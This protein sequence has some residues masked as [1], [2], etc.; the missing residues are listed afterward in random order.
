VPPAD[1]RERNAM[2]NAH[3]I[4]MTVLAAAGATLLTSV[5]LAPSTAVAAESQ[6]LGA[7]VGKPLRAAQEAMNAKDWDTALTHIAEAKAIEP[8]TPYEAFMI[9]ELTWYTT[10]QKKDNAGAATALASAV[11]SGFVPEADLPQRYKVLTQLNYQL[12]DY[13][14]AIEY[15][16]KHLGL[17]PGSADVGTIV[18][19]SLYQQKDYAAARAMAEKTAALSTPPNEQLL[20]IQLRSSY[21]LKDQAGTV[22]ALES[23]V[24]NYPQPKYWEDLLNSQLY[25]TKSD[26][27]LRALYR[28]M[29]DTD[30]LDKADECS[31][32]AGVLMS[33]G[34]PTE[35]RQVLEQ[36]MA[37]GLFQGEMQTRAQA[38][39]QRARTAADADRKDVPGAEQALASAKTGNEMVATGKLLF[40][41]GEYEKAAD[42]IQ[43]GLAKGGVPDSDDANALLGIAQARAGKATEAAA[44]FDAIKDAKLGEVAR[45]WK[46]YLE[47]K[48]KP[49]VGG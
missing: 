46:I 12:Q 43:K 32:A 49:P 33:G 40:S 28:L 2:K 1:G 23:L 29:V 14:K 22:R 13:A 21:E 42:A 8:K 47:T 37:A 3:L 36:G 5:S 44:A 48:A 24:R 26:R 9:D 15:G 25:Q 4:L 11:A 10:L 7:K 6:K 19:H 31:E 41:V 38:E 45:L 27:D 18:A 20:M 30:T 39:L 17:A 16:N 34:F 35:A